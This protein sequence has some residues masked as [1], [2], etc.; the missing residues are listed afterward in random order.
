MSWP[1]GAT[2]PRSHRS[3]S[4]VQQFRRHAHAFCRVVEPGETWGC[5]LT[6]LIGDAAHPTTPALGQGGCMALE[7]RCCDMLKRRIHK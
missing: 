3:F 6:T 4:K 7:V 2:A 5:E 1:L